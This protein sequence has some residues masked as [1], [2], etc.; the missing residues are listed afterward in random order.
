MYSF[1]LKLSI[2][3]GGLNCG[4][5]FRLSFAL[6]GL[7]A[8]LFLSSLVSNAA[9]QRTIIFELEP[10]YVT[11]DRKPAPE[12][13]S[14]F[15][16]RRDDSAALPS[17]EAVKW[18]SRAE[19]HPL[20]H[21]IFSL[22]VPDD[23]SSGDWLRRLEAATGV[24][25]AEPSP[26][27]YTCAFTDKGRDDYD[28]PPNDPYYP[29]QWSLHKVHAPAAWDISR[30]DTN[31]V[32]AI[33][34]VGVDIDHGDLQG[35]Y[36]IN[37]AEL[38]GAQFVDDD[39]NGFIDDVYGWDFVD[40][41]S[42]PR[43]ASE[44]DSHGTHVAGIAAAATD[45]GYG[46]AGMGWDCRFMAVRTGFG[47]IIT[48]GYEGVVYAAASGAD[49]ISLSWGSD[50]ASNVE[51]LTV[52]YAT[53]KGALVVG[54]AGNISARNFDHYPSAYEQV[55]AVAAVTG[56][57]RLAYFSNFG[58]FVN[59]CAPGD[60]IIST[61]PGRYDS[62][63]LLS[64]TS[65][66]TPLV[67]G[68]AGLLKA[69]H[70]DWSP[71]QLMLQLMNT[72]DPVDNHNPEYAGMMGTGRLNVFR[73]LYEDRSGFELTT[74]ALD[75]ST[76]GNSNGVIDPD[77][78]IF[79]KLSI[80]NVLTRSAVVSGRVVCDDNY[81]TIGSESFD[82]G[83]VGPDEIVDNGDDPFRASISRSAQAGRIFECELRLSGSDVIDQALPFTI[84]VRSPY[85]D[86]DNGTV[87]LTVTD[88]G[89]L[90]YC[91]YRHGEDVG[92]SF[93]YSRNNFPSLYHGSLMIA[94]PPDRV[95]D[96][97][98]GDSRKSRFDF[99]TTGQGMVVRYDEPDMMH[100]RAE[101]EDTRAERPMN[102]MVYQDS[103]SF[104]DPPD[105]DYFIISYDII[106]NGPTIDSLYAGL[107]LDWDDVQADRNSCFWDEQN[108]VGW[109]EF[110]QPNWPLYG[111]GVLDKPASFHVAAP[112]YEVMPGSRAWS[113]ST[114]MIKILT[115]FSEAESDET[116]D[117]TQLIGSG[118]FHLGQ[119]YHVVVTFAILAGDDRDDL[120]ANIA[121]ARDRW[122]AF[123]DAILSD[124]VPSGFRL[125]AAYPS[126]FNSGIKVTCSTD[127]HGLVTW[128]LY[129]PTGRLVIPGDGFFT[130]AGRFTLP[131]DAVGLPS[132]YYMVRLKQAGR[133]LIVPVT[134]VR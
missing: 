52:E 57:D 20:L 35:K 121:A 15:S 50:D 37:A 66:S 82:F 51:R 2:D 12:W 118:P 96:C 104:S 9:P 84:V 77:E 106:N 54:A 62:F 134:L 113:D 53:E 91:D 119:G 122:N 97:A 7:L 127:M 42:D 126:P 13:L 1:I 120:F 92:N 21:G 39:G 26:V 30:G 132:G 100:G 125:I 8:L 76:E 17:L 90:G 105:D 33:V 98:Y 115:G 131:I 11:A 123:E 40:N 41:D 129:D 99:V 112:N 74:L 16:A 19:D 117:W 75:D 94:A 133:R 55:M 48:H 78:D 27:R 86:H 81:I 101:F 6:Y 47:T 56:G 93:R 72:A 89:A 67:A 88:F 102:L 124:H 79:I 83:E 14:Q 36:W 64:G 130:G 116:G 68:A 38:A 80:T 49:I 63:A 23:E 71:R 31:V 69:I 43:P 58:E 59:I 32:I 107:F 28:A 65:M 18:H 109:M 34:D 4:Y 25:W 73:A 46:I 3:A 87:S 60:T 10:A 44:N 5:R 103:Y 128:S 45:N 95:S 61:V 110:A 24:A 70:P 85:A 114:K 111:A 29:L 22:Q 108:Q